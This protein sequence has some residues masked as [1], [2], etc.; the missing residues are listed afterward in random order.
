MKIKKDLG[1]L[2]K[3]KLY[4]LDCFALT[5]SNSACVCFFGF[6]SDQQMLSYNPG[7]YSCSIPSIFQADLPNL[8]KLCTGSR[9]P[10][11]PLRHL[12]KLQSAHGEAFLHFAKSH[13]FIDGKRTCCSTY[14]MFSG[15]KEAINI[16][17]DN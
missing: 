10:L 1:F 15:K 7:I 13:L 5:H 2:S 11:V 8:Q 6:F 3:A 4:S 14:R 17:F 12:S 9:L 16:F